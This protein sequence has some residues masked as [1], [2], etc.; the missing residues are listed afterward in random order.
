MIFKMSLNEI[1]QEM[2]VEVDQLTLVEKQGGL[3]MVCYCIHRS[4]LQS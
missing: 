2:K 1:E 4:T 3:I